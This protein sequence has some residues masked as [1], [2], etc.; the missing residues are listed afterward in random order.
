MQRISASRWGQLELCSTIERPELTAKGKEHPDLPT[1]LEANLKH[2]TVSL[3]T[4]DTVWEVYRDPKWRW[5][6]SSRSATMSAILCALCAW[7]LLEEVAQVSMERH[8]CA[9]QLVVFIEAAGIGTGGGWGADVV[10]CACCKVVCRPRGTDLLWGRVVL[11]DEHRSSRV[12]SAVNGK[13]PCEEELDHE[14]PH[15][16]C[17]LEAPSRAAANM[18][19]NGE[20]RWR[21]L[22]L[23]YWPDQGALPAKG[24]E[25]PGLGYKRV[26][27]RLPKAQQLQ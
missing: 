6:S 1:S 4:W 13:Q 12:S 24:K 14:Q 11:V 19:R 21:P 23:C 16:A 17:R 5:S 27:D 8:E 9:K 15:Q 18:Q 25:Y 7:L 26:R 20:S 3:S 10:L 22:E 2:I